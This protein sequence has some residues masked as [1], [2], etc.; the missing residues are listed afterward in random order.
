M[1]RLELFERLGL[2]LAIGLLI[3]LE[4]GWRERD[5]SE[6]SRTAG[7][8]TFTLIGLLGGIWG[9][10]VPPLGA[11]PLA[12][13]GL[14]LAAAF[15]LF[16]WREMVAR[17]EYSVTSVVVALVDFALGAFAVLG[18]QTVAGA[19]AVATV[20]L[21]VARRNLHEFV[22]QLT[23]PELRSGLLLLAMTFILLPTLPDRPLDPWG[24][25]NPHEL[26]LMT[27][28]IA[29]VCFVGYAG[30]RILGE[31]TGLLLSSAVG[32]LVSSTTVT[33]N[34]SRLA[35]NGGPKESG[36]LAASICGAWIVS[37]LRMSTI[38]VVINIAMLRPL[39]PP[40][41]SAAIVF[42]LAMPYFQRQSDRQA[43][44]MSSLFENPLD[45]GFVLKFGAF[46]SVI[47]VAANLANRSLG[48]SGVLGLA[49]ISGFA[50]V[51]PITLSVSRLAGGTM[52]IADAGNAILLAAIANMVTKM[53]ATVVLG[54]W[55]FGLPLVATGMAAIG[56]GAA[57]WFFIGV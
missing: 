30:V 26:W 28:L 36:I 43:G 47:T 15:T 3:G 52:P 49:G 37:I 10:M 19:A 16:Y 57:A 55:H 56:V 23:W 38:A 13:A 11:L 48:E 39:A 17:Q 54:G 4:R 53:S 7:V 33:I 6:G 46:L 22:R 50:D 51:D 27:V 18:D 35:R 5:A 31:H 9:V 40:I 45:L 34:N 41:F 24:T 32:G 44:A 25:F 1:D 14:A 2:A 8:R 20:A 12:A 42:A 21:L 29:V